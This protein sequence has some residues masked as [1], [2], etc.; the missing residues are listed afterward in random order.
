MLVGSVTKDILPYLVGSRPKIDLVSL[1]REVF[2]VPETKKVQEL[3][4][5][6]K[7]KKTNIAIVVDEWGGTSGLVTLEDIVEEVTG[8]I[9]DP[10]DI[11]K[12]PIETNSDG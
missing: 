10:F 6:F 2:F 9:R 11:E 3:L 5:D 1:S 12:I 4:N 8:E 7:L